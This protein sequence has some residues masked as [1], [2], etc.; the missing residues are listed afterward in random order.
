[1]DPGQEVGDLDGGGLGVDLQAGAG[2]E[3]REHLA[4]PVDHDLP[5]VLGEHL[6]VYRDHFEDP[7][8]RPVA[9]HEHAVAVERGE[10]EQIPGRRGLRLCSRA[11][12]H[13]G[14]SSSREGRSPA[15]GW[16]RAGRSRPIGGRT[17]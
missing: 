4:E 9:A 12:A 2:V 7:H 16:V 10:V 5:A 6:G 3:V 8:E 13:S 15:A 11:A 1:M 14:R 17:A